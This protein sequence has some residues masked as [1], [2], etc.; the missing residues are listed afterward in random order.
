[1]INAL[2]IAA[3]I[4]L[5]IWCI[6]YY[7]TPVNPDYVELY[8]LSNGTFDL[9][10]QLSLKLLTDPSNSAPTVD[11][12][13]RRAYIRDTN[14]LRAQ[15]EVGTRTRSRRVGRQAVANPQLLINAVAADYAFVLAGIGQD[16]VNEDWMV[17]QILRFT[18][19]FATAP[20]ARP[21]NQHYVMTGEAEANRARSAT[22][23]ATDAREVYLT[24]MAKVADD[25][26][27]VHDTS[28]NDSLLKFYKELVSSN[29]NN[30][31]ERD[32]D[33]H[34]DIKEYVATGDFDELTKARA[35][36]AL[37][38]FD[39]ST[40]SK[41]NTTLEHILAIAWNAPHSK[42]AVVAGLAACIESG[43][44]VCVVGCAN[45]VLYEVFLIQQ[46]KNG[47][48]DTIMTLD[49]YKNQI[50]HEVAE[51][52]EQNTNDKEQE[53]SEK[54]H[55]RE[56]ISAHLRTYEGTLDCEFINKM[57]VYCELAI[58]F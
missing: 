23:N 53:D 5:L 42:D 50:L 28:V 47:G 56:L 57:R 34:T 18:N 26:Q 52:I 37:V 40:I 31:Y 8:K 55:L 2:V 32:N 46:Q 48:T 24:A 12:A 36:Q 7:C 15:D 30:E 22:T 13:F 45:R 54:D 14:I 49:M 11:V 17:A 43:V 10:A 35:L 16:A 27:N 33:A 20:N 25:T 19:D 6:W 29:N 21:A 44:P 1:M 4:L 41:Y 39:E 51:L 38:K 9:P 58:S 3:T